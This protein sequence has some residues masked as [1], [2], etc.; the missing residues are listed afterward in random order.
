MTVLLLCVNKSGGFEIWY[1]HE[2]AKEW[3][4][5]FG[6]MSLE[7]R[8]FQHDDPVACSREIIDVWVE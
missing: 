3:C 2:Q 7:E 1:Y 4:T 8:M 6:S 5:A